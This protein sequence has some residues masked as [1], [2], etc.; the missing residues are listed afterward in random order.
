MPICIYL[1]K[2]NCPSCGLFENEWNILKKS[3]LS[4]YIK[5]VKFESQDNYNI[6]P[7]LNVY[8]TW[9]PSIVL[10]DPDTYYLYYTKDNEYADTWSEKGLIKGIKF[11]AILDENKYTY[12]GLP[13]QAYV[14]ELWLKKS[15]QYILNESYDN[16]RIF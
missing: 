14:I 2:K 6:P 11:N 7:Y 12:I 1:S 10:C 15:Y 13:N 16:I 3:Y 4:K 5:F 8:A 9:F